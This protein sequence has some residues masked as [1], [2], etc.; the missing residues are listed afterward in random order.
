MSMRSEYEDEYLS[1]SMKPEYEYE[2]W[3]ISSDWDNLAA[4]T[5][6]PMQAGPLPQRSG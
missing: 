2:G 4:L 5:V 6:F 1:M 3:P